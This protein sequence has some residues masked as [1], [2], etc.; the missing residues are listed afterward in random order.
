MQFKQVMGREIGNGS[1]PFFVAE[2]GICHQGSLEIAM[3]LVNAAYE[4]GAD[5]IKT[6]T[7]QRDNIVLDKTMT[8]EYKIKGV[9]YSENLFEH[10][11]KY[12]LT[13]DE[14]A[15]IKQLCDKLDIPFMS[16]AHDFESVDFLKSIK[17]A[18][19]KISSAD[20]IHFPLIRYAAK[21][22]CPLFIDTGGAYQ[23]EIE[24]TCKEAL[25]S[26]AVGVVFNHHPGGHPAPAENYDLRIINRLQNILKIPVGTADHY[27]GY[28]MI[29]AASALGADV[30]EKPISLDRHLIKP[31]HQ[32]SISIKDLKQV[33]S[34]MR[35][36]HSALGVDERKKIKI[37]TN[38]VAL[39]A[40]KRLKKGSSITFDNIIFG[41]PGNKGISVE[42]W[43]I[44]K[45]R[46]I[47]NSK[48]QYDFIEWDDI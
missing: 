2:L 7:F 40:K 4:A 25:D 12:Q 16:T 39:A 34:G 26:G 24:R 15:Q 3:Q 38:R 8:M 19:I 29:Y 48:N 43:D 31:E 21:S 35:A 42:Y 47:L 14:H 6:E 20:I 32:Y 46:R 13:F 28:E 37:S 22:G 30:I 18:A 45:D 27:E 33:L 36:V 10:M 9:Q 23:Y 5:C 11:E 44:V 1:S 17:A 41:R